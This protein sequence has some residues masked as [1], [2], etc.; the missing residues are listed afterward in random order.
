V[1]YEEATRRI[2]EIRSESANN[3]N[4]TS[5]GKR[6]ALTKIDDTYYPQEKSIKEKLSANDMARGTSIQETDTYKGRN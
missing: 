3:W 4:R 6:Y 2:N 1:K 5:H